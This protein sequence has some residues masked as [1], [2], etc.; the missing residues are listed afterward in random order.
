MRIEVILF[1]IVMI[2]FVLDLIRELT[3]LRDIKST[4]YCTHCN[5]FNEEISRIGKCKKCSR[6]MKIK[7]N[8]W[9]HLLIHKVNWITTDSGSEVFKWKE[10]RKLSLVEITLDICAIIILIVAIAIG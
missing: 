4:F 3:V 2:G 1:G 7:G 6:K 5:T 9:E 10:Y 8:T